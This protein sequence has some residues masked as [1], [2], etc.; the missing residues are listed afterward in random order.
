MNLK[1]MKVSLFEITYKKKITYLLKLNIIYLLIYWDAPVD[2]PQHTLRGHWTF[3]R[4]RSA[5]L[6]K[7]MNQLFSVTHNYMSMTNKVAAEIWCSSKQTTDAV[8]M[9]TLED[10]R[11]LN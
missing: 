7:N 1:Y 8:L 5:W 2:D 6:L 9:N 10:S 3:V 11:L 4:A